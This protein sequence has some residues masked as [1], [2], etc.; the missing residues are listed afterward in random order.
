M[1]KSPFYF[2]SFSIVLFSLIA[3]EEKKY[4]DA[5]SPSEA[6]KSFQLHDEFNIEVYAS[7]PFVL[8]PVEMIFDEQGLAWVVEMYDYPYKPEKGKE[9]GRIKI[10]FDTD[11]DGSIDSSKIFADKLLEATSIL[12]WKEGLLVTS[13][14]YI[15]YLKDTNN[16]YTADVKEILFSGFFD[17]NSEAQITNLRFG[18]DNWIY[19]S[20]NGQA[21]EVTF[22]RDPDAKPVSTRGGDFRFRL[23]KNL[24]ELEAGGAQFGQAMDDWGNRFITQNTLHIRH[25]VIPWRYTHR[26]PYLPST[27]V[28]HNIS[29]HDLEMFQDTPPPYWR[30]ERTRRRQIEYKEQ[31]LDREEY[32]E[33]HFTGCSGGTFFSG[34]GFPEGFYGSI[35]T[36]DVAGNLIHRDILQPL[37]D[38]PTFVA[39]RDAKETTRE[40]L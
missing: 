30:A 40:F 20:N 4:S 1:K 19:A 11:G 36:G 8:D 17:N 39:Q 12:P 9:I 34:N 3:C 31:G 26:H 29:D 13:A 18:V 5:L 32:A 7:E 6:L 22:H 37:K 35:F 23:D 28:S 16:D 14:P 10:L 21:G 2:L 27:N 15:L 33:D 24:F 25:V 38:S